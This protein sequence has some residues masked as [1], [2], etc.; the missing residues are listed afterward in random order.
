M[1][2][3]GIAP[4]QLSVQVRSRTLLPFHRTTMPASNAYPCAQILYQTV[5]RIL[6]HAVLIIVN[7]NATFHEFLTDSDVLPASLRPYLSSTLQRILSGSLRI[8]SQLPESYNA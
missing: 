1:L 8:L 3:S 2:P 6:H 7:V 4:D 5:I